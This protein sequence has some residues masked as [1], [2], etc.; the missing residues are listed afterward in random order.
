MSNPRFS[1]GVLGLDSAEKDLRVG[2]EMGDVGVEALPNDRGFMYSSTRSFTHVIT[3]RLSKN[4]AKDGTLDKSGCFTLFQ[5]LTSI[6]VHQN[7][8]RCQLLCF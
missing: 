1:F 8:G 6:V 5:I 2:M 7:S 3:V 4:L